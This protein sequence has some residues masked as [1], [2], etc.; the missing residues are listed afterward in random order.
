MKFIRTISSSLLW[1]ER[2]LVV[3]L[4]T[5]MVLLAFLQVILRNV[6]AE[7]IL[8]ADPL[9]RHMVLWVGF[10]GASLATQREKHINIDLITRFLSPKKKNFIRIGTHLFASAVCWFLAKSGWTFLQLAIESEDV[11]LTIG[12]VS[13]PSWWF[14][15]IIPIGFG[16]MALRFLIAAL[17]RTMEAVRPSAAPRQTASVPTPKA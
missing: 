2:S 8:W 5:V 6:F 3:L 1:V 15:A 11:L 4:L 7:G 17:E 10:L 14:Q 12:E 9:L 16:L 13:Y